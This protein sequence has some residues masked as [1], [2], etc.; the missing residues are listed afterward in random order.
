MVL[1]LAM[2]APDSPHLEEIQNESWSRWTEDVLTVSKSSCSAAS[3]LAQ[4]QNECSTI[5]ALRLAMRG[6][7]F[8]TTRLLY[9]TSLQP[10]PE[11][12]LVDAFTQTA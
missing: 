10:I 2:G 3:A 8:Q 4:L 7:M 6:K 9:Q 12:K 5:C 11:P 1:L